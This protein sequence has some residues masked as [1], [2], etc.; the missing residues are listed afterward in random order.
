MV[1]HTA[2]VDNMADKMTDRME[3]KMADTMVDMD[4]SRWR[5]SE[6]LPGTHK[7]QAGH[8]YMVDKVVVSIVTEEW[9]KVVGEDKADKANLAETDHSSSGMHP[10]FRIDYSLDSFVSRIL[11]SGFGRV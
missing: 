1:A 6:G 10:V 3:D 7:P 5:V 4:S 2:Q 9:D 8:R 11:E